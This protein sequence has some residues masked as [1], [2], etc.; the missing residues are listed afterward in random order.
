MK[1]ICRPSYPVL[2]RDTAGDHVL[3]DK[4]SIGFDVFFIAIVL[5]TVSGMIVFLSFVATEL[6]VVREPVSAEKGNMRA[7]FP[8]YSR[9]EK[10]RTAPF[11][12]EEGYEEDTC[13]ATPYK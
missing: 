1:T 2:S 12:M 10:E 9:R 5:A 7:L 4:G 11:I 6:S 8:G 3:R 13:Q